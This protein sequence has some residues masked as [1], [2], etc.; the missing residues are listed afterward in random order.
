MG[1]SFDSKGVICVSVL[2]QDVCGDK[3]P[4]CAIATSLINV[5]LILRL[6]YKVKKNSLCG[7]HFRPSV[8]P[9]VCDLV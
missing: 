7:D 6:L 1:R 2:Q 8:R 4:S 5:S 9:S 3:R